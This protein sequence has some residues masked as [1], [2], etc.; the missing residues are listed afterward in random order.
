MV[1]FLLP[2]NSRVRRGQAYPAP[3]GST[4]VKHF[5]IYR[6][7]PE[8]GQASEDSEIVDLI[9]NEALRLG[10]EQQDLTEPDIQQRMIGAI[11]EEGQSILADGIANKASDLDVIWINGYG[12]PRWRGGPMYCA[13]VRTK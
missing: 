2:A 10:V 12:F 1:Q 13:A 6:Y 9:R 5:T 4:S 11:A 7:D 3:A 8:T